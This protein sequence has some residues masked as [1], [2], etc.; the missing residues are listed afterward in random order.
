MRIGFSEKQAAFQ[1]EVR[2]FLAT[3]LNGEP[4]FPT[5]YGLVGHGSIEFSKKWPRKAGS[6]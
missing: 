6:E 5:G 3:E 2:D 4:F 1:K